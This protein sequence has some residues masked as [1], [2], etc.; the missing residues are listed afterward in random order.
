MVQSTTLG[1]VLVTHADE[2]VQ[3]FVSALRENGLPPAGTT[4]AQLVDHVPRLL[5]EIAE[6]L[7]APTRPRADSPE[8]E[9]TARE[10]GTNRW[11]LGYDIEQLT[12]E[13]DVLR[14]CILQFC[15]EHQCSIPLGEVDVFTGCLGAALAEAIAE[16]VRH[17]DL[18]TK[19]R[20]EAQSL[21]YEAGDILIASLDIQATLRRLS[22]LLVRRL[23]VY[24]CI[25]LEDF[26]VSDNPLLAHTDPARE[27]SLR[28]AIR[29]TTN[30]GWRHG[31]PFARNPERAQLGG[32]TVTVTADDEDSDA[33]REL[34][35]RIEARSWI[36]APLQTQHA[37][38]GTLVVVRDSSAAAYA[39]K[40]VPLVEEL[41]RRIAMAI[42]NARLYQK[43]QQE[44][45]RVERALRAKDEFVA[46]ISHEL[47]T[48]LN[49]VSGWLTLLRTGQ[50]SA[51][52]A[53]HALDIIDRNCKA[54]ARIVE[55]LLDISR[56]VTGNIRIHPAQLDLTSVVDM[57]VESARP[58]AE[59]KRISIE[60]EMEESEAIL[61]GDSQRLQQ[62]VWNLLTNA[63]KFTP[64][65]GRIRVSLRRNRSTLELTI[66]D[67][68]EGIPA[69]VLPK[70]F[71]P[72]YQ[73]DSTTARRHAGLG[74]GLAIVRYLVELHG[75]SVEASSKGLGHG[76]AFTIR[77][78]MSPAISTTL[79][80]TKIPTES[81]S[82]TLPALPVALTGT[83]VLVVDDEQD[84]RELVATILE[85][86]GAEVRVAPGATE[87][88]E[89][90]TSFMADVVV[91]DIGM[92][93]RDGFDLLRAMREMDERRVPTIALTGRASEDDV[94]RAT[95]AGFDLYLT[96]PVEPSKLV[97]T[98]ADLV[99]AA[100]P[101]S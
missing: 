85:T 49:S 68:G 89:V 46:V 4:R 100:K 5:A 58:A 87:A 8:I 95:V 13:F 82:A 17:R 75:G 79:G 15:E 23:S 65:D 76:A 93:G 33:R 36:V 16:Y 24:C 77:L 80:I 30:P 54:Q 63:I 3:C 74:L 10:H 37:L 27:D 59:A 34:L 11:E 20:V 22:R 84:T 92:P 25:E 83:K 26:E 96:K 19:E 14:H 47:R 44:R 57:V 99:Q 6:R 1:E 18:D 38:Q 67:S 7:K 31:Y 43:A 40:D 71:E 90:F 86:A 32:A 60:R 94:T 39:A 51:D 9:E 12:R 62:V 53:E 48:P 28:Q 69:H 29:A 42:D 72:F 35:D 61:R 73:L 91:T 97:T 2:I 64:K 50:L 98:V 101:P 78:P 66:A 81:F 70:L 52:R 45:Q 55:D 56:L 88:M 21:L 41:A